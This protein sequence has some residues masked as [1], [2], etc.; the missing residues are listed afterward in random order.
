MVGQGLGWLGQLGHCVI[1]ETSP[2]WLGVGAGLV[3]QWELGGFH[4]LLGSCCCRG[5]SLLRVG[6]GL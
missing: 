5:S 3:V 1:L 6:G 2:T 4:D